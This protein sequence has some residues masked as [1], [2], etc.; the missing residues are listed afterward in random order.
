MAKPWQ[1]LKRLAALLGVTVAVATTPALAASTPT[2][3]P[4][5]PGQTGVS[6][7]PVPHDK[8][9]SAS[10]T[11]LEMG[12]LPL[13]AVVRDKVRVLNIGPDRL[14]IDLY[15]ADA[16]PAVNGGFGFS[17][18]SETTKDVGSWIHLAAR[19]LDLPGHST[20]TVSF[21]IAIPQ[22]VSG[23]GEH[24]GAIVAEPS[25]TSGSGVQT[26]TRFAMAVYLRLP[27]APAVQP[28]AHPQTAVT[29]TKLQTGTKG[30]DV[31]PV[32]SYRNDT[33]DV[34]D[35][36]VTMSLHSSLGF[37]TKKA[38]IPHLG[39]ILPGAHATTHLPCFAGAAPGPSK[40]KLV[41]TSPQGARS[42][43]Q[44]IGVYPWPLFLALLLLLLLLLLVA[45]ELYKRWRE[46]Q[47]E[48]EAL[49]AAVHGRSGS[50][51]TPG[52]G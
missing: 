21:T 13:G 29:V 23:G 42:I 46:R 7:T 4:A 17:A 12:D 38:T 22:T 16:I 5:A 34:I 52:T 45:R 35:P 19:H 30:R 1:R 27:G 47:R 50:P 2:P 10:G 11:H 25:V 3:A 6:V 43:Q 44:D 48:I 40:L 51:G 36:S 24:V 15:G 32:M 31:C 20:T 9:A 28:P 33:P 26:K 41:V 14:P 8:Y 37:G 49:R 39:G 18:E